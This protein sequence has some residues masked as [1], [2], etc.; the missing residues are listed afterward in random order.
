MRPSRLGAL[1]LALVATMV[2]VASAPAQACAKS[3]N[4]ATRP[5]RAGDDLVQRAIASRSIGQL[6]HRGPPR[7]LPSSS[8]SI[9]ITS[10]PPS[11]RRWF[12]STLRS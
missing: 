7:P 3:S 1:M 2:P 5:D 10:M 9:V 11:R 6:M 12:V 4:G 8:P